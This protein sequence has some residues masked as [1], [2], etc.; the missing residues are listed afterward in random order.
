MFVLGHVGLGLASAT[1]ID[2]VV[3]RLR[4]PASQAGSGQVW[5]RLSHVGKTVD[6]RLL[7]VGSLLPDIIDKPLGIYLLGDVFANGRIFSHTLLFLLALTAVGWAVWRRWRKTGVLAL[8]FGVLAHLIFD[9]MWTLPG[10]LLWPLAGVSFPRDV[11][12]GS[13]AA[14]ELHGLVTHASAYVPEILGGAVLLYLFVWLIARKR[15]WRCV[16]TGRF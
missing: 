4:H 6:V 7:L 15:L 3:T 1:A 14:E 11:H 13:Y 9:A 16:R 12:P 10:T 2:A 8:A 5:D